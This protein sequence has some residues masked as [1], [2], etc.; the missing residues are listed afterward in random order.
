MKRVLSPQEEFDIDGEN[1]TITIHK[2][3]GALDFYLECMR[4]FARPE[5]M[6]YEVP[7][8]EYL[9]R[10]QCIGGWKYVGWEKIIPQDITFS[11]HKE[12][13]KKT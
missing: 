9:N 13:E 8:I 11:I 6:D 1:Q 7:V 2:K 3:I 5:F 12:E 10:V 4:I